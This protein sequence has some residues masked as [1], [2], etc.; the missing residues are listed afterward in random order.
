MTEVFLSSSSVRAP[1]NAL[2]VAWGQLV[3]FDIFLNSEDETQSFDIPCDDGGGFA[4]VWCPEGAAS[5]AIPF[6]RSQ[7]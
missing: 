2:F 6:F 5:D 1:Q 4:D 3:S 7:V